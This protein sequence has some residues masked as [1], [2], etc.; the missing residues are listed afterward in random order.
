MGDHW[1]AACDAYRVAKRH[2]NRSELWVISAGY[3]LT[4]SSK[5]IKSYSA[6]FASG[7]VD[8]VWRGSSEGNRRECLQQWWRTLPHDAGL[9]D[10]LDRGDG[11]VVVAAGEAYLA[12]LAADLADLL[13]HDA[14]GDRV[15]V[16]SAGMRGNGA[17]LPVSGQFRAAVGGTDAALNARVLALLAAEAPNHGF[18]RSGMTATLARWALNLPTR[19]RRVGKS[20]SDEEVVRRIL[21]IR[22]GLPSISRTQALREF[23]RAGVACE[24]SR[25]ASIWERAIS[26]VSQWPPKTQ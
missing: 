26:E 15:S 17:L 19:D 10:L 9:P 18:R 4:S 21:T 24:Q 6:T 20:V 23:R 3:G 7:S 22:D 1:H 11:V 16:L 5:P 14:S 25:F 13:K 8:S 2:S 12:A